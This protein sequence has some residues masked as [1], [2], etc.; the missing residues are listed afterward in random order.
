MVRRETP[1]ICAAWSNE[2][3]RPIRGTSGVSKVVSIVAGSGALLAFI[4]LMETP[5]MPISKGTPDT[6][7]ARIVAFCRK[8]LL[9]F[10]LMGYDDSRG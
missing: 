10:E 3:L 8:F 2:T 6:R 9:G 4:P 1:R 7:N 5:V